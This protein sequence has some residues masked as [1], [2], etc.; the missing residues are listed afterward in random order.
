MDTK[1]LIHKSCINMGEFSGRHYPCRPSLIAACKRPC[2]RSACSTGKA[3]RAALMAAKCQAA[4]SGVYSTS[5]GDRKR[6][7]RQGSYMQ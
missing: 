5:E 3:C 2:R 7:G 4:Q 1:N 6:A